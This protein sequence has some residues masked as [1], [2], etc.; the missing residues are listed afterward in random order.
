MLTYL[1]HVIYLFMYEFWVGEGEREEWQQSI[2]H[3]GCGDLQK[4]KG[5][6][7]AQQPEETLLE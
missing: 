4:I 2:L 7:E 3:W 6:V 5:N 1:S